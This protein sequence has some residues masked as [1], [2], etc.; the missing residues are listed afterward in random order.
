MK[1]ISAHEAKARFGQIL[2]TAQHE[3][4]TIEKH[5]RAV[6]VMLSKEEYDDIEALKLEHLRAEVQ[7]GINAI[8]GGHYTEYKIGEL[9]K[10]TDRIKTEGR[11]RTLTK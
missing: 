1:N 5:G 4:V 11:K 3:P 2:D 7:K 10:L 9:H 6:V 8:E